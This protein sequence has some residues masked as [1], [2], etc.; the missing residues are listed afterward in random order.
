MWA[1]TTGKTYSSLLNKDGIG[2]VKP[3]SYQLPNSAYTYGKSGGQDQYG[4][5]ESKKKNPMN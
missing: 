3:C 1:K 4:V 5:R 2:Q